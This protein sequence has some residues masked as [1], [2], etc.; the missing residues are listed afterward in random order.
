MSL[1][2]DPTAQHA[3]PV[4]ERAR[5][6]HEKRTGHAPAHVASAPA[7]WILAG[8]NVDHF[9]GATLIGLS[10]L[11]AAVAFSP[12]DD[13]QLVFAASAP[14]S[15]DVVATAP[16]GEPADADHPLAKRWG[17]LVHQLIQRQVLSRD[18]AGLDVTVISDIP[19]GA[20]LGALWAADSAMCLALAA[21]HAE[22]NEA[23]FRARLADIASQAVDA[24][25]SLTGLRSRHTAA[26][27]ASGTGI[28][29]IDY[30]DGS[31]TE[32]PHPGREG[33]RFFSVAE[34]F[35][36]AD[37]GEV[38]RIAAHR[39]FIDAACAN[40]GVT[41][42]RKLPDAID[43][44]VEWVTARRTVGDETAPTPE[45]ARA[46]VHFCEAETLRSMAVAKALRSRHTNDL[47]SLVNSPTEARG[48]TLPDALVELCKTR[49]AVAA[50]PAATGTSKA[51]LA[52]VSV[53]TADE[54]ARTMA[55]DFD[56]VEITPGRTACLEDAPA[57]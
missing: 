14:A 16:L 7:T 8:E 9:G 54:F 56:I 15:E 3:T 36:E 55:K 1:W 33:V 11:R 26:L 50:R 46:W 10:S 29:V 34:K 37:D 23:P 18:T 39:A 13:H 27:R 52:L 12:R 53:R 6:A 21:G 4:A 28:A 24:Y 22:L 45:Q 57:D 49:G 40:F 44:V 41:S 51:V 43:R 30:A 35:G 17:G 19:L 42:L 31:L 20:G 32:A 47:F 25:S 2:T 38:E 5:T 48:L